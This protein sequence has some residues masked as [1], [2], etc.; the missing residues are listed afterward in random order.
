MSATSSPSASG[1][2]TGSPVGSA[3]YVGGPSP[4]YAGTPRTASPGCSDSPAPTTEA[5]LPSL[6]GSPSAVDA[7]DGPPPTSASG[8]GFRAAGNVTG[9]APTAEG[10]Q[11]AGAR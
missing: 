6:D 3:S 4:T 7:P 9:P 10:A 11:G 2:A 1:S 5:A 8:S